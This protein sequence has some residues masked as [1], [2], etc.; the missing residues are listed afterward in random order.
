MSPVLFVTTLLLSLTTL[1]ICC[2]PTYIR[3]YSTYLWQNYWYLSLFWGFSSPVHSN[4]LITSALSLSLSIWRSHKT[5][6]FYCHLFNPFNGLSVLS[7]SILFIILLSLLQAH[8]D[9]TRA[10]WLMTP[11]AA[12]ANYNARPRRHAVLRLRKRLL[13]VRRRREV[14]IA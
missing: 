7:Y 5:H 6:F 14:T 3:H 11:N 1:L 9:E 8:L 10:L 2:H 4:I 12:A 13:R